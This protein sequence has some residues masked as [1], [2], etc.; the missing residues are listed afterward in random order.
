[1]SIALRLLKASCLATIGI[2]VIA[3]A[4]T[5]P[6]L[7]AP[8]RF[9][10]DLTRFEFG[11]TALSSEARILSAISGGMLIGWGAM[12]YALASGP[13]A[14]GD[15]VARRVFTLSVLAWFTFDSLGSLL[16]GWPGNVVLNLV[17][18]ELL[19]GP[20]WLLSRQA[21]RALTPQA[22]PVAP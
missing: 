18:L 19:L 20:I 11:A 10:F 21:K 17:F 9:I 13:I 16:A 7:D 4:A 22:S 12:L 6:A 5:V 14:G 2:G 1:M 8:W 3:V 15:A